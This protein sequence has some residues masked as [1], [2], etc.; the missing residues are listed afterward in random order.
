MQDTD[1][2]SFS[3][4]EDLGNDWFTSKP[5]SDTEKVLKFD[6]DRKAMI[7]AFAIKIEPGQAPPSSL[8]PLPPFARTLALNIDRDEPTKYFVTDLIDQATPAGP[9]AAVVDD[10]MI[11]FSFV[12]RK[13]FTMESAMKALPIFCQIT[14]DAGWTHLRPRMMGK[15]MKE[16]LSRKFQ[17]QIIRT[18][19]EKDTFSIEEQAK[20]AFMIGDKDYDILTMLFA[21]RLRSQMDYNIANGGNY[22][23]LY[24]SLSDS[25]RR[26]AASGGLP[27]SSLLKPQIDILNKIIYGQYLNVNV[28]FEDA[29]AAGEQISP[30]TF[31]YQT[32]YNGVGNDAT[33][34]L[35]NGY[36]GNVLLKTS[37]SNDLIVVPERVAGSNR[38]YGDQTPD[39]FAAQQFY[40]S[41]PDLFTWIDRNETPPT[42][43]RCAKRR[44]LSIT[45]HLKPGFKVTSQLSEN[46]YLVSAPVAYS[47]LPAEFRAKVDQVTATL[48]EQYKDA[49]PGQY[50]APVRSGSK[51]PPQ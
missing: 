3:G 28:D 1:Y 2:L 17:A 32:F 50:G 8:S 5:K 44:Q 13:E 29:K 21:Q 35:P 16:R 31:D 30:E 26:S 45:L 18:A 15:Y 7:D 47:G 38:W 41:R 36:S 43:F 42:K 46:K 23:R 40:R 33:E 12:Q 9:V 4:M 14:S 39:E 22:A 37:E 27:V 11:F 20:I 25:Q 6:P 48:K 19:S 34:L 51:I 49:K 10:Q 24:G